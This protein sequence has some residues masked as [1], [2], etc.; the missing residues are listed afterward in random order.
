MLWLG[1]EGFVDDEQADQ[2]VHGGPEK[3]VHHYPFEHYARWQADH[4][5]LAPHLP[6]PGA[7]GENLSTAGM[8]EETVCVGDV[9]RLGGARAGV[10][11]APALLEAGRTLRPA[12]ITGCRSRARCV[13]VTRLNCW[14]DCIR[15]GRWRGCCG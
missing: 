7:F 5:E 3:A 1:E 11:G 14:Y 13:S 2:R 9:Y 12:G 4:P 10:A 6:E 8:V 15:T